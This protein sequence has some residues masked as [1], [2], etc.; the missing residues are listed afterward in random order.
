MTSTTSKLKGHK[1]AIY[2]KEVELPHRGWVYI[3]DEQG[4]LCFITPDGKVIKQVGQCNRCGEC[5]KLYPPV[6]FETEQGICKYLVYD[7]KSGLYSCKIHYNK[8]YRCKYFPF[9]PTMRR[10]EWI[11]PFKPSKCTL[12]YEY[13]GKILDEETFKKVLYG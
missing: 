6:G 11:S 10:G 12:N 5:C 13:E 9:L 7:K 8:P 3:V 1:L 2:G 4:L